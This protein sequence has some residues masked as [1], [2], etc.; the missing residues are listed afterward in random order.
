M[1][2]CLRRPDGKVARSTHT[3]LRAVRE[4]LAAR[5]LGSAFVDLLLGNEEPD[6][7]VV[8]RLLA[9]DR[10]VVSARVFHHLAPRERRGARLLRQRLAGGCPVMELR[11]GLDRPD[12]H[13]RQGDRLAAIVAELLACDPFDPADPLPRHLVRGLQDGRFSN[14]DDILGREEFELTSL[15]GIGERTVQALRE[16]VLRKTGAL[17]GRM[18]LATVRRRL[19]PP[20]A[21]RLDTTTRMVAELPEWTW[22]LDL[23]LLEGLPR[24]AKVMLARHGVRSPVDLIRFTEAQMLRWPR[25]GAG[26]LERLREGIRRLGRRAREAGS[27]EALVRREAGSTPLLARVRSA[28]SEMRARER[29]IFRARILSRRP[30]APTFRELGEELGV[31][32][33]RVQAIQRRALRRVDP[34]GSLARVADERL[35]ACLSG[36]RSP[37]SLPL[38]EAKDGWFGGAAA[39]PHGFRRLLKALGCRHAVQRS[40]DRAAP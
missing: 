10:I 18:T 2:C 12:R 35:S 26:S 34:G 1:H 40:E 38:L 14:L 31:S 21:R 24:S 5:P 9:A 33:T 27:A 32:G 25:F 39:H 37:L 6:P 11:K 28:A 22:R 20:E 19:H 16:W 3:S 13:A 8:A 4:R 15:E 36:R 7:A 17:N 23:R 30:S 29:R